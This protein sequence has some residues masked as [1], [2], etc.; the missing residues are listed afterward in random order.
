MELFLK[1]LPKGVD[2]LQQ[3]VYALILEFLANLLAETTEPLDWDGL[4]ASLG[5]NTGCKV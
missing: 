5:M 2:A 4:K 3:I 1:E